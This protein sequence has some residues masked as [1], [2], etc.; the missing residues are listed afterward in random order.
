MSKPW[1]V[2]TSVEDS[3]PGLDR[4]LVTAYIRTIYRI[5]DPAFDVAIG[6]LLPALERWLLE[7][8]LD[9]F[10][11]IT[12]ENPGSRLLSAHE[13]ARRQA[14]LQKALLP[15]VPVEP[16]RAVHISASGEWP[17]ENSWWAPGLPPE[18]A[19]ALGRA[20]AQ[21]ALVFWQRGRGAALWWL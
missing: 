3:L 7:R 13:N 5:L 18:E 19:V 17:P 4:R 14:A 20:F 2:L 12:A 8:D 21:N 16:R 1:V 15:L 9:T 10:A 6:P 11:F